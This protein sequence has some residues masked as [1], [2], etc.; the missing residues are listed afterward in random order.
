VRQDTRE[1][2]KGLIIIAVF[3]AIMALKEKY[4]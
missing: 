3:A 4:W 1:A 2:I